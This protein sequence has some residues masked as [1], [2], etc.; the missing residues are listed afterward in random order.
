MALNEKFSAFMAKAGDVAQAAA[1][2]ANEVAAIAKAKASILAEED[3]IKKAQLELGK[4]YYADFTAGEDPNAEQYLPWCEKITASKQQI[5]VLKAQIEDL[6]A[7]VQDEDVVTEED[8]ADEEALPEI[9][10][11]IVDAEPVEP[12][13]PET[14]E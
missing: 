3:K 4:L 1:K 2:K 5:E 14:N 11:E 8:F 10:I 12:E 7:P 9:E 6:K 13:N